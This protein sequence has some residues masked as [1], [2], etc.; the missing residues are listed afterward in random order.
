MLLI[1]GSSMNVSIMSLFFWDLLKFHED[2][3]NII[4]DGLFHCAF[5]HCTQC[6][7]NNQ[8]YV[9]IGKAF[10]PILLC[11]WPDM[12]RPRTVWSVFS[13]SVVQLSQ[14]FSSASLS[15][16]F[17]IL[18]LYFWSGPRLCQSMGAGCSIVLNFQHPSKLL[19]SDS[20]C[21]FCFP[22][23][24]VYLPLRYIVC[25]SGHYKKPNWIGW[26]FSMTPILLNLQAKWM[27]A[28]SPTRSFFGICFRR[29]T[30]FSMESSGTKVTNIYDVH[31]IQSL[32]VY[33]HNNFTFHH[34]ACKKDEQGAAS[35]SHC[36]KWSQNIWDDDKN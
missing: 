21:S 30:D 4:I 8:Q 36:T 32:C 31:H 7:T 2:I 25:T 10:L 24:H 3:Y 26:G 33:Q 28:L 23:Y 15:V 16:L 14:Q 22:M 20:Y 17:S 35:S 34:R 11:L 18:V 13:M 27:A 6:N 19:C 1:C 5:Q 29:C 9:N 12:A